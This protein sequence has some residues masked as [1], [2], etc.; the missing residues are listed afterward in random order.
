[1][2][3]EAEVTEETAE[4]AAGAGQVVRAVTCSFF[5]SN[6][7]QD[8]REASNLRRHRL[9]LRRELDV[10]VAGV[11]LLAVAARQVAVDHAAVALAQ[12]AQRVDVDALLVEVH[13]EL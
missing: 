6:S 5:A 10:A 3:V 4:V 13:E 11:R 9:A 2:E 12:A 7:S 8:E 1:M